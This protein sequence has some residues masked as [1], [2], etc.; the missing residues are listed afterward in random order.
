MARSRKNKAP[1]PAPRARKAA[2]RAPRASRAPKDPPS[3]RWAVGL[4]CLV[5]AGLALLFWAR[6]KLVTGVPRTAYAAPATR[7]AAGPRAAPGPGST[8]R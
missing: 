6:L 3:R 7:A 1:L 8:T 2:P 5:L 4:L